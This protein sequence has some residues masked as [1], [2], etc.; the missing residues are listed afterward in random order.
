MSLS[1]EIETLLPRLRRFARAATANK[2]LAD[3][4]VERAL[5]TLIDSEGEP[6]RHQDLSGQV[7]LYRAVEKELER[8]AGG[9]FEK[10]A[11]RALILVFVEEFSPF[12]AGRI[13]G[14]SAE[15]VK[16]MVMSAETQVRKVLSQDSR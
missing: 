5:M 13:L 4:C 8:Q 2:D 12:E 10:Q 11:W 3:R 15:K 6:T 1:D 7:R 14:I 16:E 9:S